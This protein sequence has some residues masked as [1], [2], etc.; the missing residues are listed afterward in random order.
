LFSC[1]LFVHDGVRHKHLLVPFYAGQMTKQDSVVFMDLF[2]IKVHGDGAMQALWLFLQKYITMKDRGRWDTL[3]EDIKFVGP[4]DAL[5][6][7][8]LEYQLE[9]QLAVHVQ[10]HTLMGVMST[11]RQNR[12]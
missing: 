6:L 1:M 8:E 11:N 7:C 4:V 10:L 12:T 3:A 5:P 2:K 9:Y